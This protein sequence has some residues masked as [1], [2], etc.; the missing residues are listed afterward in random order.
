MGKTDCTR[1]TAARLQK[2]LSSHAYTTL[3]DL[4]GAGQYAIKAITNHANTNDVTGLH[5]ASYDDPRDLLAPMQKIEDHILGLARVRLAVVAMT[6][7][8]QQEATQ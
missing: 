1:I 3:A 6:Q 8:T 5:Y 7:N 4:S 2:P